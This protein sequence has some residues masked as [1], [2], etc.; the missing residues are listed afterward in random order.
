M[1]SADFLE[2]HALVALACTTGAFCPLASARKAELASA[3]L[4]RLIAAPS[5]R[6]ACMLR[7][8]WAVGRA[9]CGKLAGAACGYRATTSVRLASRR[10]IAR[11]HILDAVPTTMTDARFTCCSDFCRPRAN[12]C[13]FST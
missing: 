8:A 10:G 6:D 1:S 3:G 7:A 4:A 11:G 9:T 2:R 5:A 12:T 13:V